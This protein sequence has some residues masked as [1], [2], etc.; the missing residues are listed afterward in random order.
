MPLTYLMSVIMEL[1]LLGMDGVVPNP[2]QRRFGAGG[3]S[4]AYSNQVAAGGEGGAGSG[5]LA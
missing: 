3:S 4:S 1:D 5:D 2:E